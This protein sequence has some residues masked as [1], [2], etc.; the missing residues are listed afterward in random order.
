M[1]KLKIA[2]KAAEDLTA[3]KN[4]INDTLLSPQSATTTLTA[5]MS[6]I[7]TLTTLPFRGR[8]LSSVLNIHTD[9]RFL[10]CN[11]YLI[12]YRVSTSALLIIR[13]LYAKRNYV[14]LL[15]GNSADYQ[16]NMDIS[17]LHEL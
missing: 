2:P 10:V 7:R 11:N 5:L 16:P 4:Y 9:Y 14:K 8:P 15:F 6:K 13:V 3:I 17:K 1:Y 12:F